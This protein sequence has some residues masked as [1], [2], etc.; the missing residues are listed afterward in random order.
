MAQYV[1]AL[2]KSPL[3]QTLNITPTPFRHYVGGKS[4]FRSVFL[5][6]G[7]SGS[8]SWRLFVEKGQEPRQK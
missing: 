6:I 5:D 3:G 1:H 2:K 7:I 4:L 8:Y